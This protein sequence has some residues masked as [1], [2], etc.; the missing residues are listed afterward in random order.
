ML[1]S[2]VIATLP[3]KGCVDTR[4]EVALW[5]ML[6]GGGV[7]L[8]GGKDWRGTEVP[9]VLDSACWGLETCPTTPCISV[10][11]DR[12]SSDWFFFL[13]LLFPDLDS[14][15]TGAVVKPAT[16]VVGA[17]GGVGAA[18]SLRF[19]PR[20]GGRVMPDNF[21][22]Q[23]SLWCSRPP[24]K[25]FGPKDLEDSGRGGGSCRVYFDDQVP[26]SS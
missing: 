16:E 25:H 1:P 17:L 23:A 9:E 24:S 15:E 22:G 20:A 6:I 4:G 3:G 11:A 10:S 8:C 18:A 13:L 7:V 14:S 26:A 21:A 5:V 19:L 12:T 2:E